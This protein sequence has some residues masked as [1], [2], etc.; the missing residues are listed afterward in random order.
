MTQPNMRSGLPVPMARVVDQAHFRSSPGTASA[1]LRIDRV[2]RTVVPQVA[3]NDDAPREW[4][5]IRNPL[6]I[7][8]I[9]MAVLF[10][11]MALIVA[12]D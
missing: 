7:I 1:V 2:P 11:A 9:G 5:E 12:L 3:A 4:Y 6:W 8:V 10:A